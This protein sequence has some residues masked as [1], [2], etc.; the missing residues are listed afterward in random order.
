MFSY[1]YVDQAKINSHLDITYG[2]FNV[3]LIFFY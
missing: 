2:N 3:I 1:A